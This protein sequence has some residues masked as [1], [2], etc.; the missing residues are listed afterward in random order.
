[1]NARFN[2][3]NSA[4]PSPCPAALPWLQRKCACGSGKTGLQG[5][6][7]DCQRKQ[8]LG[9]QARLEIGPVDDPLEQEADRVANEVLGRS[10]NGA[11]PLL[12]G[13]A[14]APAMRLTPKPGGGHGKGTAAPASVDQVLR[15]P[16]QPLG[17]AT[18]AFFEPRFGHDFGHV[19]VH[20]DSQAAASAHAVQARA[21]T[22]GRDLVFA[23]GAY[24]PHSRAGQHLLAH[25][26][27]HVLQQTPALRRNPATPDKAAPAT[28]PDPLCA[29]F[30]FAAARGDVE[31]QAA[32]FLADGDLLPLIRSL[33]PIRRCA[34][35]EQQTQVRGAL[36]SAA[37]PAAKADEAWAAAGTAFGGY[38]GFYPGF[39][40]DI[41]THLGKLGASESLSSGKFELSPKGSTHRSRA[42]ATAASGSAD[43]AR[44]DIV[45]FRG[46]QYA[47]YKAP[48]H[49]ANGDESQGVDLRYFEKAGGYA[50]VKLM[51]ST[52]CA[53][54]CQEAAAA[55]S[56]LFPNAVILGYRKSAPIEG[57]QVRADLTQR[58]N[59][60]TRPLLLDQ[61]VDVAAI[62]S[63]W[64]SV[65]ESRHK[66]QTG[67][68]AGYYQG[69]TVTYWDG[70]AWQSIT[71][72]DAKNACKVKGD[73][74]GQY[75]APT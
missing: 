34:T 50:N 64:R 13:A 37:V 27:T 15:T 51:I 4:R 8:A 11:S 38:V 3:Q 22:V 1:M 30:D 58:I 12:A 61:P 33:K 5:S 39:A 47:Q 67:P 24:A 59:A 75:P 16:G 44:S 25:E 70:T 28:E 42:K 72:A 48:G 52:S 74:R 57:A 69:G 54:L 73:F 66:G 41:K 45:Y 40:P 62:I 23:S 68:Q 49:F 20:A 63:I 9:L 60:L 14:V 21:Y 17:A 43:L 65:V 2:A 35:P 55:F 18:R 71:A 7:P 31:A 29:S 36:A 32:R 53:T 19:R 46:H 6:C 56:S 10:A 26:L